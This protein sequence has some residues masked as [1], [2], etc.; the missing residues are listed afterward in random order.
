[1][2]KK[3]LLITDGFYFYD[4]DI[5]AEIEKLG[6]DVKLFQSN[7]TLSYMEKLFHKRDKKAYQE[8]KKK[9]KQTALLEEEQYD[10]VLVICGHNLN[11][12]IFGKFCEKQK[13]ARFILYFWDEV[14]RFDTYDRIGKFF[15][16]VITFD[17]NDARKYRF[18]FRP[19]F[20][21]NAYRYNNQEK[22]HSFCFVGSVHSNRKKILT[23]L[24]T[25]H[26]KNDDSV[27]IY[28]LT[29]FYSMIKNRLVS[30]ITGKERINRYLRCK[31]L[32]SEKTAQM[33]ASSR[34]NLDI[35]HK[36]QRG[37]SSRT[38]ESLA[39]HT[40]VITANPDVVKYNF[41]NENNILLVDRENPVVT[42]E[43]LQKEWQDIDE[44]IIEQYSIASWARDVLADVIQTEF[45]KESER[46]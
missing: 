40:K 42:R 3:L 21:S 41:Y 44:E 16:K 34:V 45:L 27:C 35:Q 11:E 5:K 30:A 31:V 20:Y 38:L 15:H 46:I 36:T 9:K 10:I 6:Y 19:V 14:E 12:E 13:K 17:L 8:L 32:N 1:M 23:D 29:G 37:I 4:D 33:V 22:K 26:Y 2:N 18:V 25:E 43:F 28:I 24:L 39:A 7:V